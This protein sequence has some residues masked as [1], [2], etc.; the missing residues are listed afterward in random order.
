MNRKFV[1][2]QLWVPVH[3]EYIIETADRVP[4]DPEDTLKIKG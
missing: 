3:V 4:V 2:E 1:F